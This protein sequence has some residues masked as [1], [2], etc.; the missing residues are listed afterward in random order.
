MRL[1]D[2]YETLLWDVMNN[3]VQTS[4]RQ[5]ALLMRVLDVCGIAPPSVFPDLRLWHLGTRRCAKAAC[6]S[7]T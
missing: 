3:D 4:I 2:A 6:P 7:R 5:P 1:P